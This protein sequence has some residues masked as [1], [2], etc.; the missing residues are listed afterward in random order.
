MKPLSLLAALVVLPLAFAAPLRAQDPAPKPDPDQ[1]P[2]RFQDT[3]NVEEE[4][5]AVPPSSSTATKVPVPVQELPFSVS[6]V[7]ARLLV[8]Q[9]AFLLSDGLK[10]ASGVNVGTGFGVFDFFVIRGFDSLSSGLVLADGAREPESTYYPMY[11]VRQIE[12]VKGPTFLYGGELALGHGEHRAQAAGAPSGSPTSRSP[13]AASAPSKG[14][15]TATWR[16]R[17]AP[18]PS[19]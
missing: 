16:G 11:N 13:T 17:T 4:L 5:P 18:S 7:P 19:A 1:E 2:P 15:S 6:V 12:V 8:D 10:N 9:D 14:R 3:V